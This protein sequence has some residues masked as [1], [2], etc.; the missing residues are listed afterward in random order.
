[1]CM[2]F[3]VDIHMHVC[4]C[5]HDEW[6]TLCMPRYLNFC[7][8]TVR[9]FTYTIQRQCSFIFPRMFTELAS[10]EVVE[11]YFSRIDIRDGRIDLQNFKKFIAMLGSFF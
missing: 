10:K 9:T 2:Y 1:M 4:V 3:D 7:L 6:L 5:E 8:R 11:S